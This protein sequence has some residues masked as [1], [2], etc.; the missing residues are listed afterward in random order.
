MENPMTDACR[1][2]GHERERHRH[3]RAGTDCS[4]CDCLRYR[5]PRRWQ[6]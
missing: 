5:K 6:R 2:C 4:A 1:T 3:Y